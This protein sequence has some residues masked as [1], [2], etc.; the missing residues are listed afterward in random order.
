M[1]TTNNFNFETVIIRGERITLSPV[2]LKFREDIFREFTKEI[3]RFM[4][5]ASPTEIS[6]IDSFI[7]LSKEGM[8]NK[9]DLVLAITDIESGEFLGMCGLHGS[10][11]P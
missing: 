5:P 2:S 3:T 10:K 8:G 6:E 1:E 4:F 11:K 7:E 9:T